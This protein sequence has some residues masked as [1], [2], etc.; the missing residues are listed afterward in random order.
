M[1]F[2]ELA[3]QGEAQAG[4]L[5]LLVRCPY[6]PELLKHRLLILGGNAY[7]GVGDG[8]FH[9]PV[10]QDCPDVDAATL[11]GELQRV[12]KTDQARHV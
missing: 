10:V 5:D 4:A 6:L 9:H 7:S 12:G 1:Q 11:R 8:H 3:A 2:D